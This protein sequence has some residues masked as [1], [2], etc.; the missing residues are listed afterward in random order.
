MKMKL[1]T[2]SKEKLCKDLHKKLRMP[3]EEALLNQ[4]TMMRS[5]KQP[6]GM[7]SERMIKKS[8]MKTSMKSKVCQRNFTKNITINH[9]KKITV[10]S[11]IRNLMNP[12]M[13]QLLLLLAVTWLRKQ[14]TWRR[15]SSKW[16]TL[17]KIKRTTFT[18]RRTRLR[19]LLHLN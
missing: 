6:I 1:E 12:L 15:R 5:E 19:K 13:S 7:L 18:S 9:P 2:I 8:W 10:I 4:L 14:Q 3:E 16:I 11:I 17:I